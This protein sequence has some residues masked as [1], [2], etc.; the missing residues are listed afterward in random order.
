[1]LIAVGDIIVDSLLKAGI[2]PDVKVIDFRSRKISIKRTVPF[3]DCPKKGLSLENKPGTINL[4]TAE[5]LK[6]LIRKGKGWLVVDGEEDLLALPVILFS[7]LNSLVFYGH[8]QLGV[9]EV[10][11]SEKIKNRVLKIINR[12][13]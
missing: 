3:W 10:I 12:F 2:N 13:Y 9:V 8:W 5:K 6:E 4:K 11:V 1:M 7:P